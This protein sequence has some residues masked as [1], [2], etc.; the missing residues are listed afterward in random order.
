LEPFKWDIIDADRDKLGPHAAFMLTQCW[1]S[2]MF[3][4]K[5]KTAHSE[6]KEKYDCKD[7]TTNP[8]LMNEI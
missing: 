7:E 3:W 6:L 4:E 8:D 5:L 1:G 2:E